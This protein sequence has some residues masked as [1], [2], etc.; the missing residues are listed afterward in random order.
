MLDPLSRAYMILNIKPYFELAEEYVELQKKF[1]TENTFQWVSLTI[2][3]IL[4]PLF[5]LGKIIYSNT[6]SMFDVIGI[7]KIISLWLNWFKYKQL[8][9]EIR[10]WTRIVRSIGGPFISTNDPTYHMYVYADGMQRIHDKLFKRYPA[11][12]RM[13]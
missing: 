3:M 9:T 4:Q 11:S 2:E 7:H 5:I 8:N 13:C 10:E 6:F 1:L 12:Q